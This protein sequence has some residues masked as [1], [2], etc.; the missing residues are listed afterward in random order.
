MYSAVSFSVKIS[1][2][3][4]NSSNYEIRN[5]STWPKNSRHILEIKITG[6]GQ[7]ISSLAEEIVVDNNFIMGFSPADIRTITTK[8]GQFWQDKVRVK[9]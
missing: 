6:K 3:I 9:M 8:V 5:V 1:L 4:F 2:L 7:S